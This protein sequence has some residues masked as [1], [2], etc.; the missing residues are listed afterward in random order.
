MWK[1][2][3]T[4]AEKTR[5]AKTIGGRSKRG[6]KKEMRRENRNRNRKKEGR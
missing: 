4:E 1:A 6:S 5:M 3:D 2:V